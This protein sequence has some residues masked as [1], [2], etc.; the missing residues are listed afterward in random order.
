MMST[1]DLIV[2]YHSDWIWFFAKV[3][4]QE[5]VLCISQRCSNNGWVELIFTIDKKN[6]FGGWLKQF[7]KGTDVHGEQS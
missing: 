4:E 2:G 7:S 3:W 5:R 1:T 6:D